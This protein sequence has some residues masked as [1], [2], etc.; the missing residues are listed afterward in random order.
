MVLSGSIFSHSGK[1]GQ[2]VKGAMAAVSRIAVLFLSLASFHTPVISAAGPALPIPVR[3]E[4]IDS[5]IV[6]ETREFW[7][8]LPDNY[9]GTNEKYPVLYMMDGDFNFNSGI[10]GSLRYA[11]MQGEIPE[12]IIVGIK[13]TD[14]SKD[15]FPEEF[16][17][18]DGS[19]DGGRANQYLD[20]INAELIPHM[21]KNYRT[22]KFRV[23]YGT[24]NTGFTAVH[25][26]FHNPELANLFVAASATLRLPFFIEKQDHLIQDFKGGKRQLVLVMGE[27]DLPTVLSQNGELKEKIDAG[28][29]ADLTCRFVVIANGGHVP[30]DALLEGLRRHFEGW[31]ITHALSEKTFAEIRAQVD[32]RLE[33]FGLQ[34]R[35]PEEDLRNLGNSLLGEK[36]YAAALE[37]L[38]YAVDGYPDSADARVSLG[39]AYL[40]GGKPEKARESFK[41]ALL[42]S[43]GH[44]AAVAKLKELDE[45]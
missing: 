10:I 25:A 27:H 15:I 3:I 41:T 16:T 12:F 37:V 22:E 7:I 26:L 42:L 8:S 9:S 32:S 29:P 35:L 30:A 36:K 20:F 33:K 2:A 6:G 18:R 17:Y 40:Q 11:A 23:L 39:D 13:N 31:E 34:G 19:K 4:R 14:R 28:A 1:T 45:K 43:P 21:G 44:A 38:Q 24:S 5:A